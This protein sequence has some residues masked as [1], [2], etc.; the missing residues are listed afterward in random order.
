MGEN[1]KMQGVI[2]ALVTPFNKDLTVDYGKLRLLIEDQIENGVDG[3]LSM[4]TTGESPTVSNAEH[5]E[6]I[7]VTV[8]Q[9]GKRVPVIAGTGSNCTEEAILLTKEAKEVGADYTLQVA[10]YYNKPNQEGFYRHFS[11]IADRCQLPVIL[12]NIPGRSGK[13]IEPSTI[14]KLAQNPNIIGVKEAAG[15]LPQVMEIIREKPEDFLVFSGDDNLTLPFISVGAVGVIS[16]ASNVIP[17]EIGHFVKTAL[18]G[19]YAEARR[20]H[21][22][23]YPLFNAMFIDTN[24]I[25][26]KTALAM[27]NRM[28]ESF[29]LPL[30]IMEDSLRKQL[31]GVLK[32]FKLV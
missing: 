29:R 8:E 30:C 12:Y 11:E 32:D 4:G 13:N 6:I 15:S 23:L 26:V 9:A 20:L 27:M 17:K 7:R 22:E 19:N 24:P 16:V 28:K 18:A 5:L 3:L 31:K 1:K 14:L 2:T 25:P 10:P 21:Y